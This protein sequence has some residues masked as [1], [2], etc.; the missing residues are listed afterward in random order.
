[1][2]SAET[3]ALALRLYDAGRF[4]EALALLRQALADGES[5]EI[6]SDWATVQFRR[7]LAGEAE[8]GS[9]SYTHLTLPTICSV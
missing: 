3:H 9:V 1:M 6:W 2:N 5:S 4:E 8:A 7:G